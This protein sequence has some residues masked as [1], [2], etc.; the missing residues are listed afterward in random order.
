MNHIPSPHTFGVVV[1]DEWDGVFCS[2]FLLTKPLSI[3]KV[4]LLHVASPK[5]FGVV[6]KLT[7]L[8]LFLFFINERV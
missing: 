8:G 5:A 7:S 6:L 2:L 1:L 4:K 3:R